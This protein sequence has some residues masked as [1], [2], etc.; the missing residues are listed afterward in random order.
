MV[1]IRL[2]K[3]ATT[4][5]REVKS[6][7]HTISEVDDNAGRRWAEPPHHGL[8]LA[9]GVVAAIVGP[10][11]VKRITDHV[12]LATFPIC[13]S[14][15]RHDDPAELRSGAAGAE[16]KRRSGAVPRDFRPPPISSRRWSFR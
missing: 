15:G 7:T 1:G 14:A 13:R 3:L 8:V 5:A 4:L 10:E 11:M 9:G 16:E 2:R 12:F 6:R